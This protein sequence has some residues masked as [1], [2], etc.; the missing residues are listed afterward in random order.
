[1][2]A[3]TVSATAERIIVV[4]RA[5]MFLAACRRACEVAYEGDLEECA[6]EGLTQALTGPAPQLIFVDGD[7]LDDHGRAVVTR[8]RA[9][10]RFAQVSIFVVGTRF[11]VLDRW[12]L[13]AANAFAV[14]LPA[15][16][17]EVLA[18]V[19]QEGLQ[20]AKIAPEAEEPSHLKSQIQLSL[21]AS[22]N[23]PI[24]AFLLLLA[25]A[26][27]T[28]TLPELAY[29]ALINA[30]IES[31]HDVAALDAIELACRRPIPLVDVDAS[32][33]PE[34]RRWYLYAFALWM[35]LGTGDTIPTFSP[36]MQ[37]LG[38]TLGVSPRVRA[39]IQGLVESHR[40]EGTDSHET[41]PYEEFCLAMLPELEYVAGLSIA[42]PGR[43]PSRADDDV[44]EMTDDAL[45]SDD[46]AANS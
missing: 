27:Q 2:S 22:G 28:G 43:H 24:E 21:D 9:I 26:W 1:V 25:V 14:P 5:P 30:A 16:S 34:V 33:L 41:F 35:A 29:P 46:L 36:T 8:I 20:Y 12:A 18:T 3:P 40:R 32:D 6:P 45:V 23:L 10:H 42:P 11:T 13:V 39:V 31:G 44:I 19:V 17:V 4:A 15:V 37:V 7:S 38:F